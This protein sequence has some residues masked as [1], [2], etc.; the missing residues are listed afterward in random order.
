MRLPC[1]LVFC[2]SLLL[3]FSTIANPG[4]NR[5]PAPLGCGQY[6]AN[7]YGPYD[8][9]IASQ[10][11]RDTVESYH[12]TPRVEQLWGGITGPVGGDISYTLGAFPNH[13]RAIV[14]MMRLVDRLKQDPPPGAT[15]SLECYFRRGMMF[16]PSD[17]VFRMQYGLYLIAR[18]RA[19]EALKIVDQ[20]VE[21]AA[22]NPFTHFNAGMLYFDMK[23]YDKALAQA[24]RA[25][26]LGF[27]RPDLRERLS[28]VGRWVA[29]SAASAAPVIAAPAA[30]A[31]SE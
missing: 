15:M 13:P 18:N 7:Y 31:A 3:S 9:R 8:Y 21:E 20:V 19:P 23:E 10:E 6:P 5:A 1:A 11:V 30:S 12:F 16:A 28:G 4:R 2:L 14:S 24:H 25:Q 17:L 22:D 29:P 27:E 26:A